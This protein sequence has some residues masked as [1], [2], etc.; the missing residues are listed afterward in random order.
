LKPSI[1]KNKS[2]CTPG[3]AFKMKDASV[4]CGTWSPSR[5]IAHQAGYQA[6][7]GRSRLNNVDAYCRKSEF[8]RAWQQISEKNEL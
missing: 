7:F 5:V 8:L 1:N 2:N 4:L 3:I 6:K